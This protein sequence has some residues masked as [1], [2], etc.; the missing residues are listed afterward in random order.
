MTFEPNIRPDSTDA[1]TSTLRQRIMVI[2]GA[3][4]TAIQRDRPDEAGYRG[5]RF[6]D[7]PSDLQGNNDLLNLTQPQIIEAIHR[8]YLE[9]GADIIETNTFNANA[10]SLSDYGMAELA[11]ELNYAGAALARAACDQYS[12]ADAPRYVAGA[13]GPTTRTASISPDVNDPGA[14]NVTYDQLVDAY[15]E[16]AKGLVDGGADIILVE[17][18]FDTLNAKAAVFAIET[19]FEERGRRWPVIISGTITDAS[20]RTLSGQVTEAFWNSVRHAQPLAVGLN[21]ALG[22]PE[23]RPYIAEIAR[24]AD[25]FVSCYPNA[26]LPNAFAEYDETP[27]RQAGYVADFAE[28]GFVNLVGGCCG[29]TPAHIAE[30]AKVVEGKPPRQVPEIPVATRLSGLEPLNI[31]DNSLFVNIGERTNITGSARF[32]NLIKAEDYDTALSVALQ[33]VE[34]GAQVIDINMDE[35]MI[36]GVAAMDRFTRLIASEPDISRVPVMIDSS[37]WEVI[38]AGLKNVQGKPIVNSI[39]LKEGEEKFVHD[40]RLCRKYGAAVVVMAFDEQGQA[41]NLERRK[42]I[43]GRAYRILTEQVGFPAEDIIFDPNCFALATGIEEHATYGIDFI[44]ACAWI[45]ENLPGVHLSGGISN[46]S[47]SFRGNNPVREAIHAVFLY[48]AINAGLDMGIVNAGALVPYDSIDPELRDRIED[49]VLNRRP[50]AAERLLEIAERFNS[51]EKSDDSS[52]AEW[53]NLPVRERITHALVKGIDAHVDDDTE[54]LRAEIAAAGGRPIEVIEGPL[55]DGMNVVGDLFGSGKMFLPQVVKSARVMKKAVAYLLPFIEAEKQP[56]DAEHTNG[57]IVMA[58]V[59]GDVHDIGKN[60]VGVVLQCNNYTV[61]DLGVMVPAQKILAAVEEHNADIVGLSGLITPSLDEMVNFAVEMEREGLQIP[62]L[63]GGA[64]TSRAHTAV[65]VAPRRSGPVVWVKDASRSVPVAAALLDDKQRAALLEE[66]AKDYAALRERHAQKN[67]R[68]MLTL[69]KARANRT[70]IDWDGYTPPVPAQGTGIWDFHDYD[71]AELRE[72]IDWQP[73]FNAW[74][75]KGRFPDILN[76]PATGETARKLYDDAQTMLDTLIK[77]KW[78]TANGVI[79]FFPA[80]AVGDD[81]EV[82][83][84]DTRTE[85]LATL[86]NL[87]QQGEH[88]QGIPNRSLGDFVAPKETGLRD[89]IGA[90]AVT[91]GLGSQDKIME[92][93]AA[94]DDYSAIL[95]ESLADRLAE[96]FAERMHQRVRTEFWG[97]QPEEHLDNDALIAEKYVGIRPA[98]GYPACPEHTEKTTLWRLMDVHSRTGIELTESM[99]MWPGAAVSGWYFSHPQSQYFVVGR[100]AQ[101]QVADYAK[102]KGWTLKEAERWL[103]SNLSYNPED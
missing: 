56:G 100:V 28:A 91:A 12:T 58:T 97:Y 41:D 4:G 38:E 39:S 5:E 40:A 103:S 49:V 51:T 15:L 95:L 34:A 2:D 75:M 45:K 62:L 23:M 59:K 67:E 42:E 87:R 24:I 68:P 73:F 37:K 76:N 77:E 63:I 14:R 96:A 8:E 22:A 21:C 80:N 6:K 17:T 74:E 89:Y 52:A 101:D 44:E 9:A 70:P 72:Y 82:Y 71:L 55:M 48:H 93:K 81:I 1:L 20:G 92:F 30:I 90:F 57:T 86:H 94:L 18:I 35:G 7:W 83:T 13:L 50:D 65:K 10:V 31:D 26:G 54:E 84:D 46:V 25:T 88:R 69:E 16:A 78:L 53:R 98:P 99:A 64:T 27:E 66:T 102:R 19:L 33:Q 29:T 79:G 32:R 61:I 36:D 60:I 43:C 47:F 85:V 11:Y 3:M